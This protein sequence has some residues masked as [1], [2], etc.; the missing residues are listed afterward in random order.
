MRYVRCINDSGHGSARIGDRSCHSLIF[1][2]DSLPISLY[3]CYISQYATVNVVSVLGNQQNVTKNINRWFLVAEGVRQQYARR[4]PVQHDVANAPQKI[5]HDATV[6]ESLSE[7][8]ING[9]DAV[10][11]TRDG[12]LFALEDYE[13]VFVNFFAPW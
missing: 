4:N 1:D 5:L 9:E 11:L 13:F 7:L 2:V 10:S 8:H 3:S 6:T 12:F